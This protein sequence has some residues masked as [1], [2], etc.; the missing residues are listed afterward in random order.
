[1]AR[2]KKSLRR[3]SIAIAVCGVVAFSSALVAPFV[4]D[5]IPAIDRNPTI[6]QLVSAAVLDPPRDTPVA[7]RPVVNLSLAIDHA[8]NDALGIEQDSPA[9]SPLRTAVYHL[10]NILIHCV[11]AIL[12]LVLI[13]RI[14]S[15]LDVD[16]LD[17]SSVAGIAALLWLV[18]PI[19]TEAVDY[20]IQRTELLVSS[21]YLLTLYSALRAWQSARANRSSRDWELAAIAACAAGMAT[22][23]VMITAPLMVVFFDRAFLYESWGALR[24][25]RRRLRLYASLFATSLIVV[26]YTV[27]GVRSHSVGVALGVSAAQYATTQAWA[28]PRYL[29]LI[30]WPN[31]LTF[32]Y[33]DAPVGGLRSALGGA[34]VALCLVATAW[35][36]L[37]SRRQLAFPGIWFF[38]LLVPSSSVI[39]IKTEIAAE[40]RVYLASAALFTLFAIGVQW[41]GHRFDLR[42]RRLKLGLVA[43]CAALVVCSF[44]RGLTYRSQESLYADVVAKAPSNPRGYVGLGL[45]EAQRGPTGFDEAAVLFRKAIS[46]DPR[47]FDAWQ[48]LGIL[49]VVDEHWSDAA[50]AFRHALRLEPGNLDAAAG[51]ARADVHLGEL[52]SAAIYV[53]RI[54]SADPEVLWMLGERLIAGRRSR[55]ALPFLERSAEAMPSGRGPALLGVAFANVGDTVDAIRAEEVATMNNDRSADVYALAA[56]AMRVLH[57]TA[58]AESYLTRAL[59]ID[60][61]SALARA[62]V[63]SMKRR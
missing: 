49:S 60:S 22:K 9:S 32:D 37:R 50:D 55:D 10:S 62:E 57:R 42:P 14:L 8:M 21:F 27:A 30:L 4:F 11:N 34:V 33:G 36:W 40:R 41:L 35:A 15:V 25:D 44:V 6:R 12:V 52:D 3:W 17:P 47:S 38:L 51:M 53:D 2:T 23:E 5:D 7:G 28:I 46:L 61:T 24:D 1:M 54:G 29:R 26:A 56:E 43:V 16:W 48:S 39:P 63:D 18:H 13:R 31:G 20:T 58:E 45:A 59:E 19:Q